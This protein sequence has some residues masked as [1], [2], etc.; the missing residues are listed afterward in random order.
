MNSLKTERGVPDY[1]RKN[2]PPSGLLA[3]LL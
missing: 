2:G 3:P 1:D